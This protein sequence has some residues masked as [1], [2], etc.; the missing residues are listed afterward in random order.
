MRGGACFVT[1]CSWICCEGL[2]G[3]Q[4]QC[5]A[6]SSSLPAHG[7]APGCVASLPLLPFAAAPSPSA[8]ASQ[9]RMAKPAVELL[10]DALGT[11]PCVCTDGSIWINQQDEF[12]GRRAEVASNGAF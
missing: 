8:A 5:T 11:M 9:G 10:A 2:S 7:A 12:D 4:A 1:G 6:R 3:V